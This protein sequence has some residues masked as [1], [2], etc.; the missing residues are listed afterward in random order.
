MRDG[1]AGELVEGDAHVFL[2]E[3]Q[4]RSV[5]GQSPRLDFGSPQEA[6]VGG[7]GL[8]PTLRRGS[9]SNSLDPQLTHGAGSTCRSHRPRTGQK[10]AR[11]GSIP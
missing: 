10:V 5:A 11:A 9:A 4:G 7:D 1:G 6:R 8:T 3:R 2:E